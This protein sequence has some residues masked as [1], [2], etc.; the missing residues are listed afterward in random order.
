MLQLGSGLVGWAD[1]VQRRN[2]WAGF[3]I[4]VIYKYFD[5]QGP[6]LAALIT[7]YGF[8]LLFPVLLIFVT[9]LG[10]VLSGHPGLQHELLH[11]ALGQFP[12]IGNRLAQVAHP[13]GG[14]AFAL[15]IGVL[16][17]LYGGLGVGQALQ[18]AFNRIWGVPRNDRPDPFRSRLRDL[19]LLVLL[20]IGA[21][22]TTALTAVTTGGSV[23][24]M[25]LG[26]W[27]RVGGTAAATVTYVALFLAVFH[28]LTARRLTRREALTSAI[29]AGLSWQ[30]L[31]Y[32]GTYYAGLKLARADAL[33]GLF[34]IVFG[35]FAWIYLEAVIVVLIAEAV[36][37][38]S[39]HLWPRSLLTPLTDKAILT[40]PDRQAYAR[41]ARSER[42]KGYERIDVD[43]TR[44]DDPADSSDPKRRGAAHDP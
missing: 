24:G 34:G 8:V 30:A 5:D 16:I 39:L 44:P 21:V 25:A 31:Q 28:V 42:F 35:L 27:A 23:Y 37:V 7:H 13:L 17:T 15:L 22:V 38:H 1:R 6:F 29:A 32:L 33:Y 11:S 19:L 9:V 2:W 36:A 18:N 41:Y 26:P 20:G 10:F 14:S 12:V 4:A 43:L 40:G 3:P